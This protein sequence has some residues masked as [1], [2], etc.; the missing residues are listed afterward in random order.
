MDLTDEYAF[1]LKASVDAKV[2][3]SEA[4]IVAQLGNIP[5]RIARALYDACA[6]LP[7]KQLNKNEDDQQGGDKHATPVHPGEFV[8]KVG[9]VWSFGT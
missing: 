3:A 2:F 5:V 9:P 8:L 7:P 1:G 6:A 4:P